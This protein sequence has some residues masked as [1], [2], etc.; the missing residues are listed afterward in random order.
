MRL[1][2]LV[3]LV[4]LSMGRRGELSFL[5]FLETGGARGCGVVIYAD[6]LCLA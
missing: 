1:G 4:L 2:R 6:F 3:V 5:V